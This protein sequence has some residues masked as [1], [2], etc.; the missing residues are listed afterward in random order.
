M[1]RSNR[2]A[3]LGLAVVAAV[4][5]AAAQTVDEVIA[6]HIEARGGEAWNE[7]E[8][9]RITGSYTAFSET[10]PFTLER[11][12][13]NRYHITLTMAGA[14]RLIGFDG[15]TAWSDGPRGPS[16]ID[17]IDRKI[18]MRD[19]EF[20][21]PFFG[22]KEKGY[23]VKLLGEVDFE[24]QRTIGIELSRPD[25]TTETWYLDPATYL[26]VGR[27]SPGND[28]LGEVER[29]AFFD[30]FREVHGVMVPFYTENQWYTRNR[31]ME[32]D[33]IE[34][35]VEVDNKLFRMPLPPGMK[36]L[37]SLV[38]SW[39]V[40]IATRQRPGDD[41]QESERSSTIAAEMNGGLLEERFTMSSGVEVRRAF[42]YDRYNERYRVTQIDSRRNWLN[43]QEGTFGEDGRL[44]ISN[45]ETGTTWSTQGMT[46]NDRAAIFNIS[47][48]GFEIE[49]ETSIDGGENWFVSGKATYTRSDG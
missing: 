41:W 28:W 47:D 27:H 1:R 12:R 14:A 35:N 18:L 15:E 25:E 4:A 37:I 20:A 21:T 17:G 5:P 45:V 19:V 34:I 16:T 40:A 33:E 32:I 31:V 26:E 11:K 9:M 46:F 22:Y 49:Y 13:D 24:G 10:A 7:I 6:K 36:E 23:T 38:G 39:N 44:V 48:D 43:V 8:T 42:S 30:D 2:L 3:T 29:S